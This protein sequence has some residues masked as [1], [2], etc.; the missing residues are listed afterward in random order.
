VK[1]DLRVLLEATAKA[2]SY[3]PKHGILLERIE[4]HGLPNIF[5]VVKW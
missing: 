1:H 3:Y 5:E 2:V 4:M